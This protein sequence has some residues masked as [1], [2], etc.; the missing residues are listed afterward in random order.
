MKNIKRKIE[1]PYEL[2]EII[3][4]YLWDKTKRICS[5]VC[6]I[7]RTVYLKSP[8]IFAN[9]EV[10]NL[11][12]LIWNKKH[13]KIWFNLLSNLNLSQV[14]TITKLPISFESNFYCEIFKNFEN[15]KKV[16]IKL[17]TGIKKEIKKKFPNVNFIEK[18]HCHYC[19]ICLWV[20]NGHCCYYI[21]NH[22]EVCY[23]KYCRKCSKD[24]L[25][26]EK[27]CFECYNKNTE[28]FYFL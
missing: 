11:E 9:K 13:T 15:L 4:T 1:L 12:S 16:Y 6:G 7:F 20:T 28:K 8:R 17:G 19:H 22:C 3:Y 23:N 2:I 21:L 26:L 5:R 14:E 27:G 24:L 18:F 25:M 10:K